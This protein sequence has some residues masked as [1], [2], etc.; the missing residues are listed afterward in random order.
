MTHLIL[1]T[2]PKTGAV[3]TSEVAQAEGVRAFPR[4]CGSRKKRQDWGLGLKFTVCARKLCC[5]P[6]TPTG[7]EDEGLPQNPGEGLLIL[8]L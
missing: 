7:L 6:P 4:A 5:L 1:L 2:P 3:V 8:P